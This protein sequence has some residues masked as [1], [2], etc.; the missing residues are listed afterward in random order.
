MMSKIY[1]MSPAEGKVIEPV[2]RD[3]NVH[4]MHMVLPEG[5]S[6]PVHN[7][8]ANVYMVVV[9][10]TL[11]LTLDET[12]TAVYPARTVINIPMGVRMHARNEAGEMLELL[13]LKAPAP[14]NQ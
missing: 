7:T 13:V 14:A 11:T 10:G 4:I 3:E 12:E 6:L 5:E 2:V 9:T 1:K 8:N